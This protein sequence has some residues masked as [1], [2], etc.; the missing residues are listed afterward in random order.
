MVQTIDELA[1]P[2]EWQERT[3][4]D[5]VRDVVTLYMHYWERESGVIKTIRSAE[6]SDAGLFQR[7]YQL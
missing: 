4:R 1:D 6:L 3:M 2:T 7:H 5:L